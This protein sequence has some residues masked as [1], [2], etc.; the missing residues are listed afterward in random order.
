MRQDRKRHRRQEANR[1]QKMRRGLRSEKTKSAKPERLSFFSWDMPF[2]SMPEKEF[3]TA[4]QKLGQE[5]ANQFNEER[6]KLEALIRNSN[7]LALLAMASASTLLR[8]ADSP[9]DFADEGEYFLSHLELLQA[10]I[11]RERPDAFTPHFVESVHLKAIMD[12]VRNL[13]RAFAFKRISDVSPETPKEERG[14]MMVSE[15]FRLHTQNV[16]NDGYIDQMHRL[17]KEL[18][19][20]LD[21][22]FRASFGLAAQSFV[23]CLYRVPDILSDRFNDHMQKCEAA[24]RE[25]S[26]VEA[27]DAYA[28]SFALK[29]AEQASLEAFVSR[30][31]LAGQELGHYLIW[32]T[33]NGIHRLY[34][35]SVDDWVTLLGPDASHDAV[36]AL[37]DRLSLQIGDLSEHNPDYFFMA[38]PVW[39]QPLITVDENRF[40]LACPSTPLSHCLEIIGFLIDENDKLKTKYLDR[41]GEFLECK[42]CELV[43][44][45]FPSAELFPGSIWRVVDAQTDEGEN[46]LLAI[47]NGVGLVFEA[48]G[49][50]IHPT[51]KRGAPLRLQGTVEKLVVAASAQAHDFIEFLKKATGPLKLSSSQGGYNEIDPRIIDTYVPIAV[52]LDTVASES[53][54]WKMLCKT[55][56]VP[57]TARPIV[58]TSI[59][60]WEIVTEILDDESL[61]LHY[62]TRRYFVEQ[63][64]N[65][66]GDELDLLVLYLDTGLDVPP[67]TD[68]SPLQLGHLSPQLHPFF[69]GRGQGVPVTKP[70]RQLTEWW[71]KL[72]VAL[73]KK[74]TKESREITF[75]LLDIAI[76]QQEKIGKEFEK[77]KRFVRSNTKGSPI[78]DCIVFETGA[79]PE[80]YCVVL[81]AIGDDLLAK[82]KDEL[83]SRMASTARKALAASTRTYAA[84]IAVHVDLKELPYSTFALIHKDGWSISAQSTVEEVLP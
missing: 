16:R 30:N 67:K 78:Q 10:F 6:P 32:Q 41:R 11:I 20:P 46:D 75:A 1:K 22:D 35:W 77:V 82:P 28:T 47:V 66:F 56:T 26:A 51:A 39:L 72:V 31:K 53:L 33:L 13:G 79:G 34:I 69:I 45:A 24:L 58:A 65:Y 71:R 38:N 48:K 8:P 17:Y 76:T 55:K 70:T 57:E 68:D 52:S 64:T 44:K 74:Q 84:V 37:V 29:A 23:D 49:G 62:L 63:R 9:N 5:W 14:T 80:R 42:L 18:L 81:M 60:D 40:F 25:N 7:P 73:W 50:T 61:L 2:A 19:A 4:F 36:A 59:W 43:K 54:C 27:V 83:H 15:Q 3:L 12:S 21:D